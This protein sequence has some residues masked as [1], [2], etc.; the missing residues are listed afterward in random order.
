MPRSIRLA[1]TFDTSHLLF[2]VPDPEKWR[3]ASEYQCLHCG[4]P[5]YVDP[6]LGEIWGCPGEFC[7]YT[8]GA[9]AHFFRP[10]F[11]IEE[12]ERQKAA[13]TK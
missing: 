4:G 1:N 10:V 6:E 2:T 11:L 12:E 8:T 3:K 9:L 7:S 13:A 5:A